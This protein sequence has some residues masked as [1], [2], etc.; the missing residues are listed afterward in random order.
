M[1]T[2]KKEIGSVLLEF[3]ENIDDRGCG[4]LRNKFDNDIP[5]TIN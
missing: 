2:H 1:E 4:T 3:C 5:Y